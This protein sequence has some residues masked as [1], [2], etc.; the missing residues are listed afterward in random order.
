MCTI[1]KMEGG[2][3]GYYSLLTSLTQQMWYQ[4]HKPPLNHTG[5]CGWSGQA[6]PYWTQPCPTVTTS[7]CEEIQTRTAQEKS[8]GYRHLGTHCSPCLA[9]PPPR[10]Q[11]PFPFTSE[12]TPPTSFSQ[13]SP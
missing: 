3:K 2:R 1:H 5:S 10:T 12:G 4:R 7:V 6:R 11:D 13:A 8:F 9:L